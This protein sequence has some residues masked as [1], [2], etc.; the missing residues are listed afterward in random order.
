MALGTVIVT[1]LGCL[2]F[3]DKTHILSPGGVSAIAI[4]LVILNIAFLVLVALAVVQQG[5]EHFWTFL[6]KA[7]ACSKAALRLVKAA[8]SFLKAPFAGKGRQPCLQLTRP[9][10]N[11]AKPVRA[12]RAGF[13]Q[14]MLSEMMVP[15]HLT[16]HSAAG[17]TIAATTERFEL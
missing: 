9:R 5:R 13:L 7:Q 16:P 11:T 10:P 14:P 17:P 2:M 8:F 4:L 1:A 3:L 12:S 6:R 15:S